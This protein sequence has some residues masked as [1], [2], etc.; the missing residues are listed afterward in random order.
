MCK[1]NFL[2]ALPVVCWFYEI[3]FAPKE[4]EEVFQE[5]VERFVKKERRRARRKKKEG[6]AVGEEDLDLARK[7]KEA[8]GKVEK[9]EDRRER[10]KE[11]M[12]R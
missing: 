11:K 7:V 4:D 6:E 10:R 8:R 1:W 3:L 9:I 2:L 5:D 12:V